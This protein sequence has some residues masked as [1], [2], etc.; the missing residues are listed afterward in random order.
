MGRPVSVIVR[1]DGPSWSAWSPQCP[2]LAMVQPATAELRTVLPEVLTWYFGQDT[3][4]DPQVH[5]E[6][7]LHGVVVRIAQDDHLYERELVAERLGEALEEAGQR[8]RLRTG[9]VG[10]GDEATLVC[11]L[12]SDRVSWLAA[13]MEHDDAVVALLPVAES[14]LWAVRFGAGRD[15]E[16]TAVS[17]PVSAYPPEITLGEVMR[18]FAGPRQHLRI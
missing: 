10:G 7:D 17:V 16:G 18:S 4:I 6:R 1:Q 12:Q 14:M 15:G 2:G 5:H 9:P 13:Q 11:A 3:E 8:R